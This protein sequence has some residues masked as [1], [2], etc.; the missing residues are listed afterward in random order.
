VSGPTAVVTCEP[1]GI[2]PTA[3]YGVPGTSPGFPCPRGPLG[4]GRLP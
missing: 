3:A 1:V 2:R 4:H